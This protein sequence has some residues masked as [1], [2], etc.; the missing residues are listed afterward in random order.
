VNE[1]NRAYVDLI[2]NEKL[3]FSAKAL[4]ETEQNLGLDADDNQTS[5]TKKH[6]QIQ[7][8]F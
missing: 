1:R 7:I 5:T 3:P 6:N 4:A 2:V 8:S